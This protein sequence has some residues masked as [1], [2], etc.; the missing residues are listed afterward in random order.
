MKINPEY[1][2]S[3]YDKYN[4][5]PVLGTFKQCNGKTCPLGILYLEEHF[6]TPDECG[7]LTPEWAKKK[8]NNQ[9]VEGFWHSFDRGR[10]LKTDEVTGLDLD[11]VDGW[12]NGVEV[13]KYL[14]QFYP[15]LKEP[16]SAVN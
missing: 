6:N 9:F 2:K 11:F 1:V 4:Y 8:F 13:R 5:I 12:N 10:I 14:E 16:A 3:L 7:I 15:N